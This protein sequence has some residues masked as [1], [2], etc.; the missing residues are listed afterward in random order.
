MSKFGKRVEVARQE[1]AVIGL[2]RF[3]TSVARTL[4]EAGHTVLGIDQDM[5]LVQRNSHL[6]TQTIQM[7]STDEEALREIDIVSYETVIVAIGTNFESNLMTAAA[8]KTLGVKTVICKATTEMQR[9]ILLRVGADRVVLP[10]FEAGERLATMITSP[11]VVS[12]MMLC[13]GYRVSEVKVP[14]ALVDRSLADS[15]LSGRFGLT[16]VALQR[17]STVI[18]T[19]KK[20]TVLREDD[21]LVVIGADEAV[22]KLSNHV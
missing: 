17:D 8:L 5:S 10:E 11:S 4:V 12:Q 22:Q 16:V 18:P 15:D 7:D 9:D 21:F 3:G 20:T 1:F 2:G 6:M 14:K 19:P 13:P